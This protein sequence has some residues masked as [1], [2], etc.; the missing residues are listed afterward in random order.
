MPDPLAQLMNMLEADPGD[1]LLHASIGAEYARIGAEEEAM[2]HLDQA[3]SIDPFCV[4]ATTHKA[5]LLRTQH[6]PEDAVKVLTEA[7]EQAR[8]AGQDT[9]TVE[10]EALLEHWT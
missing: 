5:V 10:L 1:P 7:V 2:A 8:A 9:P 4:P 3:L 6:R